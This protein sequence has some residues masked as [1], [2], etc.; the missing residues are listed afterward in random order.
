M[1]VSE[2]RQ[3]PLPACLCAGIL[4][5][6]LMYAGDLLL[7]GDTALSELSPEVVDTTMR[8]LDASRVLTGGALGPLAAFLYCVGF[9]G[10]S[11]LVRGEYRILRTAILLLFVLGA[12]YGGAYHSHFP[13]LAFSL[14]ENGRE[15]LAASRDYTELLS[16]GAFGPWG[17]GSMLFQY[18]VLRGRT[19]CRKRAALFAPLV[20]AFLVLPL[21]YLPPPFL[22]LVAGGW[23]SLSYA[24]FFA[25]CL[26]E[27]HFA[28]KLRSSGQ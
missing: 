24:V 17:L 15:T 4:G 5:A 2:N 23:L 12:V 9:Y 3:N 6:F 20:L 25:V 26:G 18:A 7:Y 10:V 1:S 11:G 28:S 16:L 13:L 27:A 19:C 14:A 21:Q 22:V 8:R